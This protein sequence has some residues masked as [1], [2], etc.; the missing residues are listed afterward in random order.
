MQNRRTEA[1]AAGRLFDQA[2]Q[3]AD[4]TLVASRF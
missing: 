2:W 1:D 4:V 3:R